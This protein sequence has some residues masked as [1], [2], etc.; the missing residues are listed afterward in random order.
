MKVKIFTFVFNRPDILQYQIDCFNNYLEDDFEFHVV[1]DTR[2]NKFLDKFI[3][4]CDKNNISLH[5]HISQPGNTPSFYNSDSVQ[6]A[7]N[8][9]VLT[10]EEDFFVI[11]LD[12]DNFLIESFNVNDFMKEC[13]FSGCI[14]TRGS[15]EYVWQGLIFFRKS[16]VENIEFDFYPLQIGEQSLD[17]CGGTYKLIRNTNI[18]FIPTD[19]QYPD[20]YKDINLKDL[21]ISNG[22]YEMELHLNGKFLHFRN[23]CNWHNGLNVIDNHKTSVL[24]TIL[25]D[26]IEV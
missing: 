21:S 18:R 22:G 8:N 16:A 12:H 25:S 5:H 13:D 20:N 11:I 15:Y 23:A 2:D 26:F 10:E 17:S 19:V 14:Q 7:Y 6:W 3:E 24:H 1:Y 4:I 9:F